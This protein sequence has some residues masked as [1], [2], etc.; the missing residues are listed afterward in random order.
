[1]PLIYEL[2][3]LYYAADENIITDFTSGLMTFPAWDY[4]LGIAVEL[5]QLGFRHRS[6][7]MWGGSTERLE[8]IFLI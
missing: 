8:Y 5:A 4:W 1:M 3:V 2:G 6:L 7:L